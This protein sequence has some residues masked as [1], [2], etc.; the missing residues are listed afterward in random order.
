MSPLFDARNA[1][2]ARE[3]ERLFGAEDVARL[4]GVDRET[5]VRRRLEAVRLNYRANAVLGLGRVGAR[6]AFV[7][8]IA[9]E[10]E[11]PMRDSCFWETADRD[12]LRSRLPGEATGSSGK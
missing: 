1:T 9:A 5:Y 3:G 12:F 7:D 6:G 4:R 11:N 10:A 8:Q 2:L